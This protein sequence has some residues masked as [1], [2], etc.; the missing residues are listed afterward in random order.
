MRGLRGLFAAL[1]VAPGLLACGG[2]AAF[3]EPAECITPPPLPTSARTGE[4]SRIAYENTLLDGVRRLQN[5]ADD[6][7]AKYPSGNFSRQQEFRLDFAE[8]ADK[9]RCLTS[10]MRS[11][12]PVTPAEEQ[13]VT[14]LNLVLDD[15]LSHTELGREAVRRRNVS[16]WR[17]W[18]DTVDAKINA[19]RAAVRVIDT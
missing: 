15:L 4:T 19:V 8:Y 10:Y 5:Y 6:F 3:P 1:I 7:R 17:Q 18:R 14:A 16:E 12:P 11:L 9:T 13:A 2:S